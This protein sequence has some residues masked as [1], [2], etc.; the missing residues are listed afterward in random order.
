MRMKSKIDLWIK[1]AIW[2]S[3]VSCTLIVIV[4]PQEERV[5]GYAICIPIILCILWIYFGTYYELRED[6]LYV[7]SG[8]FIGRIAYEKIKSIKF[9][10]N[11]TSSMALSIDRIEIRQHGK[12]YITGTT[13]ISPEEREEF[14]KELKSRC[15]K[16]DQD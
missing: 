3:V 5:I 4:L 1:I 2:L 9:S 8:P 10:R 14:M 15:K 13:Y 7:K 12:G 16:L 11:L 6:H